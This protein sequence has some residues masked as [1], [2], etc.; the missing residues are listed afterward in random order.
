VLKQCTPYTVKQKEQQLKGSYERRKKL[1]KVMSGK[2]GGRMVGC[3]ALTCMD[4]GL[5]IT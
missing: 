1:G 5:A 4:G 3:S 2:K